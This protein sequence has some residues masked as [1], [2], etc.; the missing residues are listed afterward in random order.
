MATARKAS[1]DPAGAPSRR[2][3]PWAGRAWLALVLALSLAVGASLA[4]PKVAAAALDLVLVRTL[5]AER[6]RVN[7]AAWPPALWWGRMDTLTVAA[8]N[9]RIGAL[10]VSSLDATLDHVQID[11][12]ALYTGQ[13]VTIRSLGSAVARMTV[14]QSALQE[15]LDAQPQLR[16]ARVT[17]HPGRLTVAGTVGVLGLSLRA[18]GEGRLRLRGPQAVDLVLDRVTVGGMPVPA[19]LARELVGAL[20]P[21]LDVGALPFGL[22]LTDVTVV[23]GEV[24]VN[25]AA[26]T[27]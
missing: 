21:V 24:V 17:L 8:Q 10:R 7:V 22:H 3:S 27:Q 25:A 1:A 2:G 20:N 13:Q 4:G 23:E 6:V 14:S 12:A 5:N 15:V 26:G 9:L 11:A 18:T 16:D 19:P